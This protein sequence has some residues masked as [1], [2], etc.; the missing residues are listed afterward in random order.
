MCLHRRSFITK[1]RVEFISELDGSG[2]IYLLPILY[3]NNLYKY[4]LNQNVPRTSVHQTEQKFYLRFQSHFYSRRKFTDK[5]H[6]NIGAIIMSRNFRIYNTFACQRKV[7]NFFKYRR[8]M[9]NW[10]KILKLSQTILQVNA[11]RSPITTN[12]TRIY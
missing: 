2:S 6:P 5:L 12:F 4:V 9:L 10:S 1:Y 8:I 3:Y 7:P 11:K